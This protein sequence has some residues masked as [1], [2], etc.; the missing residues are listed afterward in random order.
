MRLKPARKG[1]LGARAE[2]NTSIPTA[3]LR[4]CVSPENLK[5]DSLS[6][7]FAESKKEKANVL[8][9]MLRSPMQIGMGSFQNVKGFSAG[10]CRKFE[11]LRGKSIM[12]GRKSGTGMA[13]ARKRKPTVSK[14]SE[15]LRFSYEIQ[16]SVLT[17]CSTFFMKL[18]FQEVAAGDR[19]SVV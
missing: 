4:F 1:P 8:G 11:T 10:N 15:N 3:K 5:F 17:K 12:K 6:N 2:A 19:K 9:G 18:R 16:R 13:S 7:R 14:R